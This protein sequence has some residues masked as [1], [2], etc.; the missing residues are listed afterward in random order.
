MKYTEYGADLSLYESRSFKDAER[1]GF[2]LVEGPMPG[3]DFVE[4]RFDGDI[5]ELN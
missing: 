2:V 3:S 4:L 5:D 1:L